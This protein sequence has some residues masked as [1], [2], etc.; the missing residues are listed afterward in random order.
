M[1]ITYFPRP[2]ILSQ[3]SLRRGHAIIEASAGT[4]KTFTLEH[5]VLDL[6]I[7]NL[8]GVEQVLVV[9]F[10]DAATRELRERIRSLI[11]RVC[12]QGTAVRP[13]AKT[14]HCWEINDATRGRLQE[15]LFRFDGAAISTIHGFCQRILT[16]QAFL[17]GRLFNQ[18]HRNGPELFG[19]AFR[20]ELRLALAEKKSPVGIA[21]GAWIAE[22]K[23]TEQLQELL[24]GCYREGC[25]DRSLLTPEWDPQAFE[26]ILANLPSRDVLQTEIRAVFTDKNSIGGYDRLIEKL[27][28]ALATPSSPRNAALPIGTLASQLLEWAGGDCSINRVKTSRID[29]LLRIST[30]DA[31]SPSIQ[32]LTGQLNEA[33]RRAARECSFFVYRLLPRVQRRLKAR[34]LALGLMDYDDMLLGVQEALRGE[35]APV[36]L[37]ALRK[38]WKF[39]LV[40]EFQDTDPVQWDIFRRIFVEETDSHHLYVIGDPKQAIYGFRGAD[41]HTYRAARDHLIKDYKASRLSL[42]ENYRSTR[43]I[44]DAV[45]AILTVT[46]GTKSSFFS[47][48]NRY[49]EPV[50]CGD[51]SCFAMESDRLAVPVQLIHL[52]EEGRKMNADSLKRGLANFMAT[53]IKRLTG[54]REGLFVGRGGQAARPIRLNDIHIL[55]RSGREGRQIGEVLRRHNIHH[56]F[57]KLDGLFT[58]A[59][60]EDIYRLLTAIESPRDP[61]RRMAAWLTPFFGVPLE[62]LPGWQ[63]VGEHH[64]LM[65]RLLGWKRLA[66]AGDWAGLFEEIMTT[67][68]LIRRL[69][70]WDGERELTNYQHLFEILQREISSSPV[71]LPELARSLKARIDGRKLAEGREGDMQRL[72]TDK[73]A[74][75]I[76]T[77][78]KAKGLEAEVIF[79]AGGFGH[80]RSNDLELKIYHRDGRRCLHIGKAVGEI[81]AAIQEEERQE[82]QRLAYVALT[83]ARSRL[84]LPYFGPAPEGSPKD[85]FYGYG[86]LGDFYKGVE[87]QLE[88]LANRGG[89]DRE[90]FAL[91]AASC[92]IRPAREKGG[93]EIRPDW[94]AELLAKPVTRAEEAQRI[95]KD[96][97]GVLLTSYTRM[98][99]DAYRVLFHLQ[100][101]GVQDWRG[102]KGDEET[103]ENLTAVLS[104]SADGLSDSELPGGRETGIFLHALLEE[105]ETATLEEKS[106]EEWS[107]LPGVQRSAKLSARRHG[108]SERFV[109]PA[110][111]MIYHALQTPIRAQGRETGCILDMPGGIASGK[112]Q[113]AEMSFAYPI[114]EN[115]HPLLK[116]GKTGPAAGD[117]LPFRAG[118]GYIRGLID[119]VFEHEGKIYLLDWKSDS[120]PSFDKTAVNAH[121]EENYV[122]QAQV[123]LL[124]VLRLLDIGSPEKY[125]S[126]F[127]GILYIFIRGIGS[128]AGDSATRGVWFSRPSWGEVIGSEQELLN[129]RNWGGDVI[130]AEKGQGGLGGEQ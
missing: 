88:R 90:L 30:E 103:I 101:D 23:T 47:G 75:Q 91:R 92:R 115:G 100:E 73:E 63:M 3:N 68:G 35:N 117:R 107:A 121:V 79:V 82:N 69:I 126:L 18:E 17:G 54:P 57:Y 40:D 48:L 72:E 111:Q 123:Y 108:F 37:E 97:R 86:Q 96:R 102:E 26:K 20:E 60:A 49:D 29:H 27:F 109:F 74:V 16:E 83:R 42:K 76:L 34:K 44:I 112:H 124:A 81:K 106:F 127:G 122:L 55:T 8:A 7:N 5:L 116:D 129:C 22:G 105:T 31:A 12:D 99:Q 50:K 15:A 6:I 104:P 84:Y 36:L 125:E 114:P 11:R 65:A 80:P 98:K 51:E 94:G 41:V 14:D 28:E 56:A 2:E 24:Y 67:S 118:R 45:N 78:H 66:A 113:Q 70:F 9:T 33:I 87:E 59:E 61:A 130:M 32:N 58:T 19:L 10:T 119:L 110:L 52:Y 4:G 46:G 93:G 89:F 25:P 77:M 64:P 1:G 85:R 128:C 43:N 62:E 71:T 95:K 21:L 13:E 53:E 38:R 39:A 120:L